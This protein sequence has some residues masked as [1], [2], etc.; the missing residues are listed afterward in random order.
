MLCSE[1]SIGKRRM[2]VATASRLAEKL[3]VPDV[4]IPR[5]LYCY[6]STSSHSLAREL[7]GFAD[8]ATRFLAG[9]LTLFASC[10]FVLVLP[11]TDVMKMVLFL[12]TFGWSWSSKG[13]AANARISDK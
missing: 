13:S 6:R 2:S 11:L 4:R 10:T 9:P 8:I 12:A 5:L 3:A 7:S 1:L